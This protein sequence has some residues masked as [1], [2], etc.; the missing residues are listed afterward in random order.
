M[1]IVNAIYSPGS[2]RLRQEAQKISEVALKLKGEGFG[3]EGSEGR[4]ES[5]LFGTDTRLEFGDYN[6]NDLF[7][8]VLLDLAGNVDAQVRL[9]SN[10]GAWGA[11]WFVKAT[12]TR[13]SHRAELSFG[14]GRG[15]GCAFK[16]R[17]RDNLTCYGRAHVIL[18]TSDRTNGRQLKMENFNLYRELVRIVDPKGFVNGVY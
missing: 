6:K 2:Y 14:E 9:Y 8:E 15:I 16:Y 18:R 17:F 13:G 5:I 11:L 1:D 4:F 7:D 3:R 12:Y 10:S